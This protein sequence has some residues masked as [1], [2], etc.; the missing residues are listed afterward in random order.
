MSSQGCA[1]F[2]IQ[3]R[4]PTN[5]GPQLDVKLGSELRHKLRLGFLILKHPIPFATILKQ[6]A[7][8]EVSRR[9]WPEEVIPPGIQIFIWL[10][11]FHTVK[12]ASE[13]APKKTAAAKMST[14]QRNSSA[15]CLCI[16]P[17][18]LFGRWVE[19]VRRATSHPI[20]VEIGLGFL[21]ASHE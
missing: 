11:F 3:L 14:E 6:H 19:F 1:R 12:H 17:P 18:A 16:E 20:H 2:D 21:L 5:F 9:T 10:D 7:K 15:S 8:I 4:A 13:Q